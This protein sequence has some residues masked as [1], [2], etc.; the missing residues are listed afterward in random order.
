MKGNSFAVSFLLKK[1]KQNQNQE[2][3]IYVRV[4]VNHQRVHIA[5]KRHILPNH[6]DS[7]KD[8][9]KKPFPTYKE[10]NKH[11]LIV[12]NKLYSC[13]SEL[14]QTNKSVS[15][16]RIKEM[17]LGN[18]GKPI[19]SI[20]QLSGIHLQELEKFMGKSIS[21]NNYKKYSATHR[22]IVE[23]IHSTLKKK[24]VL[25]E[26]VNFSFL[27]QVEHF[28]QSEKNCNQN[29]MM[30]HMQRLKKIFN[31][32]VKN[33]YINIS[34][35]KSFTISYKKYDRGY[36][37]MDEINKI[38]RI[39]GVSPKLQYTR[40]FFVF[41]LYTGLAFSDMIDLKAGD[42]VTGVDNEYWIIKNRI[43]TDTKITVPLLPSALDIAL[44]YSADKLE[45]EAVFPRISNQKLNKNLK[46]LG[47]LA[48]LLKPLS[49]HLARHSAATTIWL[50]NGVSMEVVSKMLGHTKISTTQIYGRIVEGKISEEMNKLKNKLKGE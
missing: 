26:D 41:Q 50:S 29:G 38:E 31:W 5:T 21:Y 10:I 48:E 46:E 37:T 28:L 34:P 39:R 30:K 13:Y 8:E 22:Y 24:D 20:I 17:Y 6:W 33:E 15:A 4:T 25:L 35:F 23:Y 18:M 40:D 36:L 11:L 19:I 43:K 2:H 1:D 49:T 14:L 27:K 12:K 9:A 44:K 3:P 47:E 32:A 45:S 42:I 16:Q 7:K